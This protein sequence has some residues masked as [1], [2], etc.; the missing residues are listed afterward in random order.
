MVTVQEKLVSTPAQGWSFTLVREFAR[1][2]GRR[3]GYLDV[4]EFSEHLQRDMGFLDGNDPRGRS[5]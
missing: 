3:R 4:R 5:Q 1:F 2:S